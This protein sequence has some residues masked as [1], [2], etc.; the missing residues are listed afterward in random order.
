MGRGKGYTLIELMIVV[1]IMAILAMVAGTTYQRY[2]ERARDASVQTLLEN[3]ALAQLTVRAQTG[4]DLVPIIDDPAAVA[5]LNRLAL[6]GF[7]PD[8][9]VGL[10]AV[11]MPGIKE[12]FV[13]FAAHYLPGSSV[14][15][16]YFAPMVGVRRFEGPAEYASF[17][18]PALLA[19]AW[20]G[21]PPPTAVPKTK[22]TI[23]PISA[24]VAS[25]A[26]Y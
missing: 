8:P 4:E 2:I 1:A 19:S 12:G 9:Y 23:D 20:E 24:T 14:L 6:E 5:N 25:S 10:A 11:P 21:G 26:P 18:P 3:L 13:L 15:A 16:Y 7:R 17:L 22:L